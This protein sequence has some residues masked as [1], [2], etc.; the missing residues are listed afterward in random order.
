MPMLLKHIPLA[1]TTFLTIIGASWAQGVPPSVT[2]PLRQEQERLRQEQERARV[3]Q[4]PSGID[5]DA[6]RPAT[7]DTGQQ[8][9]CSDIQTVRLAGADRLDDTEQA[10]LVSPYAGRCLSAIDIQRLMGEVT[11]HYIDRG[12]TTSRVY[13]PEQNLRSGELRL[14]VQEGRIEKIEVRGDTAGRIRTDLA[15]PARP[16]DVLNIRDLEQAVDQLN[17]VQG[18]KVRLDLLAGSTPG[19][20]VVVLHNTASAPVGLLLSV[21]NMGGRTTGRHSTSATVVAGSLFHTNETISATL[22]TTVPHSR[23]RSAHSASLAYSLPLGYWTLG[24]HYAQSHFSTGF[25]LQYPSGGVQSY[26]TGE[27]TTYGASAERVLARSQ[28]ALHKASVELSTVDSKIYFEQPQ[29]QVS[30]FLAG[31]S[32][33]TTAA[34]FGTDSIWLLPDAMVTL[35]PRVVWGVADKSYLTGINSDRQ[36]TADFTKFMLSLGLKQ[37]FRLG[38]QELAWSSELRGQYSSRH[39]LPTQQIL[40]GGPPSVRGYLDSSLSGDS[41]HVW[42][43]DLSLKQQFPFAGSVAHARVYAG[44][45]IGQVRSRQADAF[46]GRLA[47]VALGVAA[48]WNQADLDLSW[49]RPVQH[50]SWMDREPARVLLRLSYRY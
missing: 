10:S 34:S 17:A 21:D 47:G 23:K 30:Q 3:P 33:R 29:N 25:V 44:Y 31:N 35:S 11:R 19:Q 42:R 15:L 32:R 14:L 45:D 46:D 8:G 37:G 13:L 4:R 26:V 18:N 7:P 12:F 5:L 41:G 22:R 28:T 1:C 16:G 27:S 20:T 2:D 6:L 38:R 49:S 24:L 39:L 9:P 43:N 48:Q 50:P 40:I 36:G